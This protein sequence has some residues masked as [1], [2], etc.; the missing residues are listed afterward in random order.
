M[1]APMDTTTVLALALD[2]ATVP[3]S[4]EVIRLTDIA[5]I[6]GSL[7]DPE[8]DPRFAARLEAVLMAE[9]DAQQTTVS[10][11]LRIVKPA[12]IQPVVEPKTAPNVIA[13][14]RRRFVVRKVVAVAIAAAMLSALPI[15][16]SASALPGS[17]FFGIEQWR[18]NNAI[19]SAHGVHRAFVE[20][21]IAR[22]WIGYS[23]EMVTLGFEA[24]KV[25]RALRHAGWLQYQAVALVAKIGGPADV[26]KLA[27]M[28]AGDATHL[29][30]IHD[31]AGPQDRQFV[32]LAIETVSQLEADLIGGSSTPITMPA[33]ATSLDASIGLADPTTSTTTSGS[34]TSAGTTSPSTKSTSPKTPTATK[35][36]DTPFPVDQTC[37]I[38]FSD[39]TGDLLAPVGEAQCNV[40]DFSKAHNL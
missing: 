30:Q 9:F 19:L 28:L 11:A 29:Q 7:P 25:D 36:P 26:A 35:I 39:K 10:P 15:I 34:Q 18:Q 33:G 13:F 22:N 5:G 2:G 37:A 4:E 14:P 3:A 17:P 27:G 38:P 23:S 24:N 32:G 1:T 20:E 21:S 31:K 6:V 12:G 16:A 8:I 40:R